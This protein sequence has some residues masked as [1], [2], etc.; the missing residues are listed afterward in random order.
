[1]MSYL[2]SL[3][4]NILIYTSAFLILSQS[5]YADPVSVTNYSAIKTEPKE[6]YSINPRFPI[7]INIGGNSNQSGIIRALS[8]DYLQLTR[9]KYGLARH[10]DI[11]VTTLRNLRNETIDIAL[12][13]DRALGKQ[14]LDQGWATNYAPIFNDHF[15]IIGPKQNPANLTKTD[16]ST[17]AFAKISNFG[18]T[19]PNPTFLSRDDNSDANIREQYIWSSLQIK[20]WSLNSNWYSKFHSFPRNALLK[21]DSASLYTLTDWETWLSNQKDL[22]NSKIYIRGG[23]VL[24]N[25]CFALL[26]ANPNK[27]TLKFLE[28]LKS[29]RAQHLIE[30]YG[31][32][33]HAGFALY[34]P[35]AKLDF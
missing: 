7:K 2:K 10:Q 6:I 32:N 3:I 19:S 35:A 20:P 17:T 4:S 34:T 15:I 24:L 1:M 23:T 33:K 30:I 18:T 21:A 26:K 8:Q 22:R 13:Y 25:Q 27:E 14:A 29:P 31:K 28:Y 9:A 5:S 11:N 16:S 12:I